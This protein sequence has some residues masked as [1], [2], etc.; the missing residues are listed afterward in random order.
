MKKE[1]RKALNKKLKYSKICS[2]CNI[3]KKLTEYHKNNDKPDG[4]QYLCKECILER[5][6]SN[7]YKTKQK[8][9]YNKYKSK[10]LVEK[11]YK[12]TVN[13][14]KEIYN[15]NLEILKQELINKGYKKLNHNKLFYI[16]EYGDLKKLPPLRQYRTNNKVFKINEVNVRINIHGYKVFHMNSK[17]HRVHQVVAE[18]YLN[19]IPCSHKLVVDHIDGNKLNNYYK[20]L[21]IISNHQNL[22]KGK[23]FK[24]NQDKFLKYIN[25][26]KL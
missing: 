11:N 20:N 13:K 12:R 19:H 25:D 24:T 14:I 8:I 21:Q 6:K 15:N 3:E 10:G 5:Q 26:I 1:E 2:K 16:N 23:Y 4:Y 18:M 22:M 9:R 7:K 17:E